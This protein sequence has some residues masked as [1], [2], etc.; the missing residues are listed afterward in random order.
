[1]T[2]RITLNLAVGSQVGAFATPYPR[3]SCGLE[4]KVDRVR[5]MCPSPSYLADAPVKITS[6]SLLEVRQE[7]KH[8]A[9][10]HP[11]LILDLSVCF[12]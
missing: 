8:E 1:M 4:N 9:R 6:I 5:V 11:L 2:L 7:S 10:G 3:V 12:L